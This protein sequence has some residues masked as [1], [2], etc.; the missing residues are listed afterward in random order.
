MIT[1][2][3]NQNLGIY[4]KNEIRIPKDYKILVIDDDEEVRHSWFDQRLSSHSKLCDTQRPDLENYLKT[5]KFDLIFL[6][7][8]LGSTLEGWELLK[9]IPET[10]AII[11]ITNNSV[12]GVKMAHF[13]INSRWIPFGEFEIKLV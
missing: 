10:T 11:G 12:A 8:D 2:E 13:N 4:V 1:E 5:E 9:W 3:Y 6:D 7:N